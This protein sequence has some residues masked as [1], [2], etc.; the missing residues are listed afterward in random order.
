[1]FLGP[2]PGSV[3]MVFKDIKLPVQIVNWSNESITVTLPPMAI[4]HDVRIRLDVILPHGQVG[5]Q[6]LLVVTPPAD[7]VLHPTAPQS[8]LPTN[9]ALQAAGLLGEVG[10]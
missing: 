6:K 9:A 1:N 8:P 4:R 3:F 5:L 2:A 7:V 10:N